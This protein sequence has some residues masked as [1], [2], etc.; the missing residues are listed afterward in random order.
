MPYKEGYNGKM[1]G[2]KMSSPK[3]M[4][5]SP[6]NPMKEAMHVPSQCGPGM[7]PDQSKCN[8]LRQKAYAERDALRGKSGM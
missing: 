2:G 6:K 3:G 4:Y 7:N 1:G 5:S 8:S